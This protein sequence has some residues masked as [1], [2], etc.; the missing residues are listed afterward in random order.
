MKRIVFLSLVF[1]G[2]FVLM[3]MP[4]W[5][6]VLTITAN[7]TVIINHHYDLKGS[8]LK[9]PEGV[10]LFFDRGSIS[11]GV[12]VGNS[13]MI[14]GKKKQIFDKILIQGSWIVEDVSPVLYKHPSDVDVLKQVFALTSND[15]KNRVYIPE[16]KYHVQVSNKERVACILKSNTI[17]VLEGE[18]I[19]E[20]NSSIKY[21]ILDITDC[22]DVIIRGFGK[23]TGDKSVHLGKDGEWGHGINI[24]SSSNVLIK[25][26]NIK[27][28]WGDC[29][30]IGGA[31]RN[32]SIS[33][34]VLDNGRRQ[35]LSVTSA[36]GVYVSDCLIQNVSG[37]TPQCAIDIETN[38]GTEI[39]S[40]YISS[41]KVVDCYGGF[42]VWG[43]AAGSKIGHIEFSD[44]S[45]SRTQT[46]F[47]MMLVYAGEVEV[48][49]CFID[50]QEKTAIIFES[51][52][53]ASSK[54][55]IIITTNPIPIK[56]VKCKNQFIE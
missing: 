29:V 53:T 34:C 13:T 38:K 5:N 16:G 7:T 2:A 47:P 48:N 41:V 51:I 52:G 26:M 42:Q 31:S 32:I 28:C 21:S 33:N 14:Q 22:S 4:I 37:T 46:A 30:Y 20:P 43:E 3:S 36:K 9:I 11:N 8:T 39:D 10:T 45:I 49:N 19:L 1:W 56:V 15:I 44:C 23:I 12:L 18:I 17:V 25:N 40:V 54:G 35:G 50:S 55:N 27:D 24:M 6:P